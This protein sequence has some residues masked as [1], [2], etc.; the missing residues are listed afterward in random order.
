VTSVDHRH[1][2]VFASSSRVG[3]RTAHNTTVHVV[4]G[5]LANSNQVRP[6]YVLHVATA[7]RGSTTHPVIPMLHAADVTPAPASVIVGTV[8]QVVPSG[9]IVAQLS[10]DDGDNRDGRSSHQLSVDTSMAKVTVDGS[11]GGSLHH[12][13]FVAVLGE[14]DGDNVLASRVYALSDVAETLR[15]TVVAINDDKVATRNYEG[16]TVVSLGSG[17]SQVPLFLNGAFAA[18]SALTE[19]DRIVVLGT[20]TEEEEG[21]VPLI[22]FAFNGHDNGPCGDN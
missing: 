8:S 18:T 16:R 14:A 6:G 10:R 12:G 3:H 1:V 5:H 17:A 20:V 2:T 7:G 22:A 21:F 15:G 11:D 19:G 13:D 4:F 9:L